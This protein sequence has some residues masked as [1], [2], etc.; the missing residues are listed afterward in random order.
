VYPPSTIPPV[1]IP[2]NQPF[3]ELNCE[4]AAHTG[5]PSIVVPAGVTDDG[6]PVGVELLG[7][8]FAE[9][10]LCELAAAVEQVG[11]HRR[12]PDGFGPVDSA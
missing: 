7:R 6:L 2:A 5:L 11:D 9:R 1:E 4:L 12:P 8:A 3:A 10:H